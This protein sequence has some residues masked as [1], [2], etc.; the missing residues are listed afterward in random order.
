MSEK[1]ECGDKSTLGANIELYCQTC[2]N[3]ISKDNI[4]KPLKAAAI[5]TLIAYGGSSF[6]N[7][8]ITDNR[9][10]LEVEHEILEACTGKTYSQLYVTR[11]VSTCLCALEDTMNEIS[12]TRLILDEDGFL[13]SFEENIKSCR[14]AERS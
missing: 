12:Y 14:N 5:A 8:A 1:C 7:Y 9:Y 4:K 13:E 3:T 11:K 10:P 6:F 2:A